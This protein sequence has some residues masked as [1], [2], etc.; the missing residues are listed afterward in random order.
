MT[1]RLGEKMKDC[2]SVCDR[3]A[4]AV[5][6]LSYK[7]TKQQCFVVRAKSNSPLEYGGR[8][9]DEMDKQTVERQYSVNIPQR[10]GRKGRKAKLSI[11]YAL[12]NVL[13]P[14]RKQKTYPPLPIYAV[15]CQEIDCA[16]GNGLHWLVL[17]T[18]SVTCAEQAR[19]IVSFYESR[20]KVELFHKAGKARGRR[21][22]VLKCISSRALKKWQ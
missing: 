13:A 17:T 21:L 22:K 6:Y 4:D 19:K 18:E 3:E 15:S 10:G 20:W 8:L 12:V 1:E 14:E 16:S 2:I 7:C 9:F 5:E 11:Q